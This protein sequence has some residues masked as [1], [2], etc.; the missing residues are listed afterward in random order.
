MYYHTT[1]KNQTMKPIY[2]LLLGVIFAGCRP[3]STGREPLPDTRDTVYNGH[4][5][6]YKGRS[7]CVEYADIMK[8]YAHNRML[9]ENTPGTKCYKHHGKSESNR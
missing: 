5:L 4:Y 7:Y 3:Y 6:A 8:M 9:C 2:L 1:T